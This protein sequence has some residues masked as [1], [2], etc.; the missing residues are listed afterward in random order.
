MD[1]TDQGAQ[2]EPLLPTSRCGCSSH[3]HTCPS[4]HLRSKRLRC[5]GFSRRCGGGEVSVGVSGRPRY[6]FPRATATWSTYS[7]MASLCLPGLRHELR[8]DMWSKVPKNPKTWYPVQTLVPKDALSVF[9][10]TANARSSP[11][12]EVR[13]GT[14]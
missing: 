4:A 13:T 2:M 11:G 12:G 14:A 1:I 3:L 7:P 6:R 8:G 9:G 10:K 5:H